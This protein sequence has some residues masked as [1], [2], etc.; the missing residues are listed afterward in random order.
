M[1][2]VSRLLVAKG[3]LKLFLCQIISTKSHAYLYEH[4]DEFLDS[5]TFQ[6]AC[7]NIDSDIHEQR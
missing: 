2:M 4:A 5:M 1:R 7:R 6:I 3:E